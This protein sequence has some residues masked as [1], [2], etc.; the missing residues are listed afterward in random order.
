[1]PISF[2]ADEILQMA[3]QIERNGVKFY[4]LAAERLAQFKDIFRQFSRQEEA[5]LAIFSGMRRSLSPA[6]RE[7]ATYDPGQE[8]GLYL[9]AMADR[10]V[11]KL[12]QDPQKLL[13][14]SVS[15]AGVIDV[16]IGSEKDSIVFYAGM[17][18]LVP[19]K[20]G[21]EKINTIISEEF[22]HIAVLRSVAING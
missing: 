16:A 7:T 19:G 10:E 22:R 1:M 8:N 3:E 13:P 15:L 5:P 6:E 20:L 11:F 12:D 2:N 18:D 21:R 14:P 9:L 17:K 4:S